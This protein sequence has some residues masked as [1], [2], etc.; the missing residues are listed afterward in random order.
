MVY[1]E[2]EFEKQWNKHNSAMQAMRKECLMCG[3]TFSTPE[4]ACCDKCRENSK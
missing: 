3:D 4:Y 1:Q 2:T